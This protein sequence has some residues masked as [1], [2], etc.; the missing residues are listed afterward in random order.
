[1]NCTL[2]SLGSAL[3]ALGIGVSGTRSER[4]F[5]S[6]PSRLQTAFPKS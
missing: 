5:L 6:R 1:M 2:L 4:G 3:L